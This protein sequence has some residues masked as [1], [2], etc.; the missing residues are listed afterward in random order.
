LDTNLLVL[1]LVGSA[2]RKYIGLHKR[3]SEFTS[4]DYD[5]LVLLISQF[6]DIVLVPHIVAETS[7]LVGQISNPAR[8]QIQLSL[9][10]L[11]ETTT[12][13]PIA[14]NYGAQRQEFQ[15]LGIT[16]AVLLHLCNLGLNGLSPTLITT[17]SRLA[18]RAL[19]LGCS[20][21]D[22][23]MEFGREAP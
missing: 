6:S 16:D 15:E 3:L 14:S 12:E 11:I 17:D 4:D 10:K 22:Y 21:I 13:V 8:V 5:L 7:N 19:S 9:K 1:L 20:V 18:N 23:K 2:S